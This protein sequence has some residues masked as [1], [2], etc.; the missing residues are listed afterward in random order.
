MKKAI[1]KL[2]I[3]EQSLLI[4]LIEL[5]PSDLIEFMKHRQDVLNIKNRPIND[6][7]LPLIESIHNKVITAPRKDYK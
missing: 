1:I 5:L 7:S 2:T 6:N 4:N 3:E